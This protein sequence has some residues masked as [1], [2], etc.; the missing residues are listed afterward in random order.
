MS[1]THIGSS[2]DELLKAEGTFEE[3]EALAVKGVLVW[4]RA[5]ATRLR[6]PGPSNDGT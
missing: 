1:K 4:Q 2:L 3:M 5:E 6:K